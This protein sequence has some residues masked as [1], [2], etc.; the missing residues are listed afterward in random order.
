M[1]RPLPTGKKSIDLAAPAVRVSRIRRDP[2]PPVKEV[3]AAEIKER[4]A[5]TIVIGVTVFALAFFVL[6]IAFGGFA[7][8]A[9]EP[10]KVELRFEN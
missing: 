7:G 6:L 2:P 3:T 4:D 1:T 8:R 5:R 9:S 10:Y